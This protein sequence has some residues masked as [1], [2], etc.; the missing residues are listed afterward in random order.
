M[1]IKSIISAV[2]A[3]IGGGMSAALER[4]RMLPRRRPFYGLGTGRHGRGK[5]KPRHRDGVKLT[6]CRPL[7]GYRPG[8]VRA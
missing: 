1:L 5:S 7:R 6:Y 3:S 8:R 4:V 2:L